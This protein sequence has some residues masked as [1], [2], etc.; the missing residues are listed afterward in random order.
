MRPS[1]V[2]IFFNRDYRIRIPLKLILVNLFRANLYVR[3]TVGVVISL[4]LS[5]FVGI[6]SSL[7]SS[8]AGSEE[9]CELV[10]ILKRRLVVVDAQCA[11]L[12]A[13]VSDKLNLSVVSFELVFNSLSLH[14][15]SLFYLS[16]F[17]S[18]CEI[19]IYATEHS[20]DVVVVGRNILR[21]CESGL[22]ILHFLLSFLDGRFQRCR[23]RIVFTQLLLIICYDGVCRRN[24]SINVS[25]CSLAVCCRK[26]ILHTVLYL[27]L[28]VVDDLR[29]LVLSLHV[30]VSLCYLF[31]VS[32]FFLLEQIHCSFVVIAFDVSYNIFVS[33]C[34]IADDS[35]IAVSVG[36]LLCLFE[37]CVESISNLLLYLLHVSTIGLFC[38]ETSFSIVVCGVEVGVDASQFLVQREER[39]VG[40][41]DACGISTH[42]VSVESVLV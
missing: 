38:I 35:C 22:R 26:I 36:S 19:S 23:E 2:I 34:E 37:E 28:E 16:F 42:A 40:S 27:E 41:L 17:L 33:L 25:R 31:N 3:R 11:C 1:E 21:C 8:I 7:D 5:L 12:V 15:L 30:G 24:M 13:T 29:T 6:I 14:C 9:V 18:F 10:S 39:L 32:A 4:L 20:D